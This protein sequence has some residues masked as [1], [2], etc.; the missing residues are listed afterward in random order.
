MASRTTRPGAREAMLRCDVAK[1]WLC[2]FVGTTCMAFVLIF[3][4]LSCLGWRVSKAWAQRSRSSCAL[5][6]THT[7]SEF[8]STDSHCE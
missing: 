7:R 3:D 5:Q 1:R 2:D 8:V 6:L 4:G